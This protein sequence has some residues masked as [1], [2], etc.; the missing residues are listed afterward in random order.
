VKSVRKMQII[1]RPNHK[2]RYNAQTVLYTVL[3]TSVHKSNFTLCYIQ[4]STFTSRTVDTR[5]VIYSF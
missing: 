1:Y 4:G 2:L 3:C 5:L